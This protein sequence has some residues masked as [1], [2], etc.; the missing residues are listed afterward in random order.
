[1]INYMTSWRNGNRSCR[2]GKPQQGRREEGHS[3]SCKRDLSAESERGETR[4]HK[5]GFRA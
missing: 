3:L 5:T 1:K 4:E 2:S